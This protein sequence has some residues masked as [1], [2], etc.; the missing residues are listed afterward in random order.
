MEVK[1][2]DRNAAPRTRQTLRL[3]SPINDPIKLTSRIN[4]KQPQLQDNRDLLDS[5]SKAGKTP[6]DSDNR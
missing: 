2:G 3:H 1:S 6:L 5:G 4:L